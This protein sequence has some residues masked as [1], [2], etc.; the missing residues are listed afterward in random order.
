M[1]KFLLPI[2]GLLL[3]GAAAQAEQV[4]CHYWS[5]VMPSG[6]SYYE[7]K[8]EVFYPTTNELEKNTDGTY[9]LKN[10]QKSGYDLKF[11]ISDGQ[12][13]FPGLATGMRLLKDDAGNNCKFHLKTIKEYPSFVAGGNIHVDAT[14][15]IYS[16][17]TASTNTYRLN[18]LTLKDEQKTQTEVRR[19]YEVRIATVFYA[20]K[21]P[22]G[23]KLPGTGS[24][25]TPAEDQMVSVTY[26]PAAVVFDLTVSEPR[27]GAQIAYQTAS[28]SELFKNSLSPV[29]ANEDGSVKLEYFAN[30]SAALTFNIDAAKIADGKAPLVFTEGVSSADPDAYQTLADA[31]F[32]LETAAGA[33]KTGALAVRPAGCYA[34]PIDGTATLVGQKYNVY[35][36]T[37][38]GDEAGYVVFEAEGPLSVALEGVVDMIYKMYGGTAVIEQ[39]KGQVIRVDENTVLVKNF[40]NSGQDIPL[41]LGEKT[42]DEG[43]DYAA[44]STIKASANYIDSDYSQYY[45]IKLPEDP[46]AEFTVSVAG[47]TCA[48]PNVYSVINWT[49]AKYY[50]ENGATRI[51]FLITF[52]GGGTFGYRTVEWDLIE[53]GDESGI[54]DVVVDENAPVEWFNLQG[55]RVNGENLTPGIYIKRQG[56]K[57]VKVLVR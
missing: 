40:L 30:S 5:L 6:S 57:A 42:V 24:E 25:D 9:S 54:Q 20:F 11:Q 43:Q 4:D 21:V 48:N 50:N 12:I 46:T 53:G 13:S 47:Q 16:Y 38:F 36:D 27:E 10:Y 18:Y 1:K 45:T 34:T 31:T 39:T 26:N 32:S 2:V 44:I 29:T 28:G 51:H 15:S 19:T 23:E 14:A 49:N 52:G 3:G 33:T 22:N 55:V 8:E 37:K 41:V 35:I 17:A 7:L 56:S